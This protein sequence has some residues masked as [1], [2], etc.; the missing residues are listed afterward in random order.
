MQFIMVEIAKDYI[1]KIPNIFDSK[2]ERAC[3]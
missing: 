3:Q 2:N 1:D